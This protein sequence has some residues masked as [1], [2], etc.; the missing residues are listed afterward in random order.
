MKIRS[1]IIRARKNIR[2][3]E[4]IGIV[5][6]RN[7]ALSVALVLL[8]ASTTSGLALRGYFAPTSE[9][10]AFDIPTQNLGAVFSF[11]PGDNVSL[12]TNNFT[13]LSNPQSQNTTV[14]NNAFFGSFRYANYST[15]ISFQEST[16]ISVTKYSYFEASVTT[17]PDYSSTSGFA[18]G[19]RFLSRLADGSI[20]LLWNDSLPSVEHV[21]SGG[22]TLLKAYVPN[23]NPNAT[24]VIAIRFYVEERA[25]IASDYNMRINSITA[26]DLQSVSHCSSPLC[27]VPIALPSTAGYFDTLVADTAFNGQSNYKVAFSYHD[28]MF[29]SGTYSN[30][31]SHVSINANQQDFTLP[32]IILASTPLVPTALY[33]ISTSVPNSVQIKN[34]KLTFTPI[35]STVH[36]SLVPLQTNLLLLF[37]MMMLV[38]VVPAEVLILRLR[39]SIALLAGIIARLAIMPWTGGGIDTLLYIRES[40]LYYHLGWAPLV[41]NPPTIFALAAPIG[42]MQFYYVL[43]LDRIDTIFLFHYG[44]VLATFFVKL[45]FLLTDLASTLIIAKVSS[46]KLYAMYYFLNPFSIF[47]SAIWGQYEGLT[48]LAIIAGYASIVSLR[49]KRSTLVGLGAFLFGGLVELF[50]FVAV[51][52]LAVYL[53]MKKYYVQ[54][55]LTASIML[56]VLLIP[57][58][59]S[60]FILSFNGSNPFLRP[61]IYSLS[62]NLGITSQLPLIAALT[63]SAAAGL[64]ILIRTSVF[65]NTLVP[66]SAAIISLE[67]FAHNLPQFMVIPLGLLTLFFTVRNDTDG[68]TFVWLSGA[69][70]AFVT[71]A[72]ALSFALLLTNE[73]YFIIPLIEGGHHLEFYAV[74]LT[75]IDATLLVRAFRKLPFLLIS[76]FVA[77]FVGLGWFLVNFV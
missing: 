2:R 77:G 76:L 41:Y 51:P 73:G 39:W 46:N 44:G 29:V 48:T 26:S 55:G 43:G 1:I 60:Q 33:L 15:A 47:V 40:Y 63:A 10:Q 50:G 61:D 71:M 37:T 8:I 38:F 27:Y 35:P 58:S 12:P 64:Y 68:L 54:F 14:S 66:L 24:T 69:I 22:T 17:S 3:L 65:A 57:S 20:V 30:G 23:Y 25:G 42:S 49:P 45:P 34:L 67:L 36:D 13:V 7:R 21:P 53:L 52:L 74:S 6:R 18:F 31:S 56:V 70:L 16:N 59:L 19:L 4:A 5:A 11:L 9:F 72:A 62:G 28:Q 75:I 32:K